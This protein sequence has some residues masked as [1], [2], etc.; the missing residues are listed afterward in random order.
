M[1]SVASGQ[2]VVT[3]CGRGVGRGPGC[4]WAQGTPGMGGG[5]GLGLGCHRHPFPLGIVPLQ[6]QSEA[7]VFQAWRHLQVR[8]GGW[9]GRLPNAV[10]RPR[11]CPTLCMTLRVRCV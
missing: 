8:A 6:T 10:Q 11:C 9:R 7:S 1:D 4:W 2:A 3:G 5:P